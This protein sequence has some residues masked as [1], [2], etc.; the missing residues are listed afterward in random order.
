MMLFTP[1]TVRDVALPNRIGVSPMCMY[2]SID[3]LPNEFHV[4]HLG[5][6]ALGGAGLVIAEA[7]AVDPVGRIS[8]FDAG[9]WDDAQVPGWQRVTAL[10]DAVGSVPGIQLGHAGRRAAVREPWRA[11]APLDDADAAAGAAPWPLVAPSAIPAGPGHQVPSAMTAAEISRSVQDWHE[12]AKRAMRAGFRFVELHG[13]HGYLLH[14]FLS[15]VSNHRTDAYGGS[16]EN[17]LRYPLEVVRAVRDAIGEGIPLS[18]RISSV[19]GAVGGLELDDMVEV[20][21]ALAAAGVDIIDT[22]SGGITTDRSSDTRVRRGFAFHADFSRRIRDEVDVLTATVGFVTDAR[23]ADLLLETGDADLVLLGR[24]MLDDPNW[25][26]HARLALG[27][28][29]FESWD[30]R[31]GSAVGPRHRTLAR[32]AEAGETPLSRFE[33]S[34]VRD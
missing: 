31:F 34:R 14:S 2:S 9:I 32:L 7:T 26:H 27:D 13:A 16:A 12:A 23:Q 25:A 8:P 17:R 24:Q 22:S 20:S 4:A 29:G 18:F 21:R 30:V 33:G 15:P 28:D 11:G 10:V 3:G 1:L 6:F 19:D 5:R